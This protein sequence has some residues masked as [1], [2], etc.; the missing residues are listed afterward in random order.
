MARSTRRK[1]DAGPKAATR[2]WLRQETQRGSRVARP[3]VALG[4]AGTS[5][6]VGQTY[7]IAR[8]LAA[9][10]T[11]HSLPILA[12]TAF[13][14]LA[15]ARAALA[16][17]AELLAAR[18]GAASRRRLRSEVMTRLLHAG[19]ACCGSVTRASWPRRSSTG[20]RRWM[21]S[22]DDGSRLDTGGRRAGAGALAALERTRSR[23]WC[24]C[25]CGL[26]VPVGDGGR[27]DRRGH[28][29]AAAVP[30]ARPGCRPASS[31]ACAASP[32]SSWPAAP[33]TRPRRSPRAAD[34]LRR[35]TM[36]VLRVAFLSSA[37]LDLA[38]AAALIFLALRYGLRHAG[39]SRR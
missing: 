6:A 31:T 25:L 2:A 14:V 26:L 7:C 8:A 22:S 3:V 5:V 21:G 29:V 13:A 19:P 39:T 11:G 10:L 32:R 24:W 38:A 30:G 36:R 12:L 4:L 35:R 23:R 1:R 27:R 28:R 9:A 33:R 37:A 18:A 15:L 20:S 34:E 17:A 16:W